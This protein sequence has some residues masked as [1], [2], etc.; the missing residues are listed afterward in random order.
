[1]DT[2]GSNALRPAG[3]C[4]DVLPPRRRPQPVSYT[5]LD[6]YKRQLPG[7]ANVTGNMAF[8]MVLAIISL[9]VILF[10]TNTHFWGHIFWPPGVPLFVKVILIPIELA[11]VLLIKPAALM[12][13][14]LYTSRCV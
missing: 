3:R 2:S 13:C 7:A 1:M 4:A 12:I 10:S 8:T 14:L 9:L 5:H 11:G 6:V